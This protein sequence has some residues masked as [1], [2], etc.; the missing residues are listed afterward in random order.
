MPFV[1]G[2]RAYPKMGSVVL[3]RIV[4]VNT[5]SSD[6]FS[7][8]SPKVLAMQNVPHQSSQVTLGLKL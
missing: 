6:T 3:V 1:S 7:F 2:T 4:I 8:Y 5:H